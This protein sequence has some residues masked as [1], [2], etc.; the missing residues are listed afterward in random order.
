M[1][2]L[3]TNSK[4]QG[5]QSEFQGFFST[6]AFLASFLRFRQQCLKMTFWGQIECRTPKPLKDKILDPPLHFLYISSSDDNRK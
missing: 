6:K 1:P 5:A 4:L 2:D 3:K